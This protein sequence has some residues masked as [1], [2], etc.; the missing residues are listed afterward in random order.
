MCMGAKSTPPP[1]PAAPPAPPAQRDADQE[2]TQA[3]QAAAARQKRSGLGS[4]NL[5]KNSLEGTPAPAAKP[6]LGA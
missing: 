2:G 5:T 1:Q 6:T 4:T 3:R